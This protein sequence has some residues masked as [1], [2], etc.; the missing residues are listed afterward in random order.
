MTGFPAAVFP[1]CKV[2]KKEQDFTDSYNDYWTHGFKDD[3]KNSEG[4]PICVQLVGYSNE[5]EKLLGILKQ[6]AAAIPHEVP[7]PPVI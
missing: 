3:A 1:V 4:L 6:M 7:M 2:E 5:D